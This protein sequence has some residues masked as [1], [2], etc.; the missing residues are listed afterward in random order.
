MP[1]PTLTL[2]ERSFVLHVSPNMSIR[3]VLEGKQ[4]QGTTES[5]IY[6]VDVTNWGATPTSPTVVAYDS[7]GRVVTTQLFPTNSPSVSGNV[8]TLSACG[9]VY[10]DEDYLVVVKFTL[11]GNGLAVTIPIRG[12]L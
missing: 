12:E 6:K 4:A 5:V 10:L 7:R 1:D 11:G 3:E 2:R 8:I 9:P